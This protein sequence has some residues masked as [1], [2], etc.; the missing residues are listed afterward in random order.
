MLAEILNCFSLLSIDG[1]PS[2]SLLGDNVQ[3]IPDIHTRN[4]NSIIVLF[5][6]QS[7]TFICIVMCAWW[8]NIC[9]YNGKRPALFEMTFSWLSKVT[10]CLKYRICMG[11]L[12]YAKYFLRGVFKWNYILINV[13]IY[14]MRP[15]HT[16]PRSPGENT[17]RPD[18]PRPD[19]NEFN[20][21]PVLSQHWPMV[22]TDQGWLW[23]HVGLSL[24]L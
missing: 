23:F 20:A 21:G 1:V 6:T 8:Y 19:G 14:I 17:I 15:D 16:S 18:A 7:I 2:I 11:L 24:T 22:H 12:L 13:V 4:Y 9:I 5:N 10:F 3:F